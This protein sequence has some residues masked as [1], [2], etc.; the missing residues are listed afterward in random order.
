MEGIRSKLHWG[1]EVNPWHKCAQ[2]S[3][4]SSLFP[5][6]H[7]PPSG[8]RQG[9]KLSLADSRFETQKTSIALFTYKPTTT[10]STCLVVWPQQVI[11]KACPRQHVKIKATHTHPAHCSCLKPVWTQKSGCSC[12]QPLAQS[13]KVGQEKHQTCLLWPGLH[14]YLIWKSFPRSLEQ[15]A[16]LELQRCHKS[17]SKDSS[18]G[19]L[20]L[21]LELTACSATVSSGGRTGLRGSPQQSRFQ[22]SAQQPRPE[23]PAMVC[24]RSLRICQREASQKTFLQLW[25]KLSC[26]SL[27]SGYGNGHLQMLCNTS[28][29]KRPS[30]LFQEL[31]REREEEMPGWAETEAVFF[32]RLCFSLFSSRAVN[33]ST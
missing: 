29:K 30:R 5:P 4:P 28:T 11:Y 2:F 6:T 10:E 22:A 32:S 8:L 18:C 12:Y 17:T 31:C 15:K 20:L 3:L 33:S 7:P 21:P 13:Y 27:G 24:A 19:L 25:W 14:P 16:A 26:R 9:Q 23:C 1:G